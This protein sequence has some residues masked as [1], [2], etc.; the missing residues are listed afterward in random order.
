MTALRHVVAASEA[1]FRLERA[2][3]RGFPSLGRRQALQCVRDGQVTVDGRRAR[4]GERVEEGALLELVGVTELGPEPEP[5]AALE[6]RLETPDVLVVAKPAGQPSV[7]LRPGE[8][9]TLAGALLG[10]FPELAS[11]GA[12]R[13]EAGLVHRL[14]TATSGLLVVA[15]TDAAWRE[16]RAGLSAGLLQKRYL[17]L[18]PTTGA[19]ATQ[20][21]GQLAHWI[22]P[23]PKSRKRVRVSERARSLPFAGAR[24]ATLTWELVERG[25]RVSLL[26]VDVAAAYRHQVRA[27]LAASGLP[28]A[29]DAL[30]GGAPVAALGARLGLHASAVAWVGTET[31]P[32]FSVTDLVPAP[33]AEAVRARRG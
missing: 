5:E 24:E 29:G 6:L 32:P 28:I 13:R 23:S 9:G 25:E 30:Y 17:A 4:A 7:G 19:V 10:Q 31:L 1:G 16:L 2:L 21:S 33:F 20:T 26:C 8:R 18:V 27:Q 15:R 14:D 11:V 22:A 3:A 12:L